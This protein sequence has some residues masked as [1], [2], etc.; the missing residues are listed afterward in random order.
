[1]KMGMKPVVTNKRYQLII[2]AIQNYIIEQ[3]LRPGD[4][5]PTENELADALQTGRSSIREA[6]KALE[7]LGV[8]ETKPGEGMFVRSFNCDPIIENLPYSMLFDRDDLEEILDIRISLELSNLQRVINNINEEH[9]NNIK[10]C[11]DQMKRALETKD[12][13]LF[14]DADE[15]FHQFL[16]I[17]VG[18]KLLLKLLNIFWSLLS[19]AKDFK[20]LAD[21]DLE[22]GYH[23]HLKIY[24]ALATQD[25]ELL[26][27]R[28]KE[29]YRSTEE[30]I[31]K[32]QKPN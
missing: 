11:L 8:I 32:I 5:L 13:R 14:V 12:I 27:Q 19:N 21:P 4:K 18:N 29:H 6:V 24:E 20:E 23:K 22:A 9:L 31:S 16:F 15:Q 17:P 7:V 1:M 10:A 30:R 3:G 28:T 25:Y 26:Y 2:K